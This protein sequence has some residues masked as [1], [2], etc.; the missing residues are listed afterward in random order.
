VSIGLKGGGR[1]KSVISALVFFFVIKAGHA[2]EIKK[3]FEIRKPR[4][5][6]SETIVTLNYSVHCS[7]SNEDEVRGFIHY[8]GRKI[9]V[10][11]FKYNTRTEVDLGTSPKTAET[12]TLEL[13]PTGS[14]QVRHVEAKVGY[15]ST[16]VTGNETED[17]LFAKLALKYSPFVNL[18]ENQYESVPNDTPLL[19]TY[20]V[21]HDS[22][23]GLTSI[24]YTVYFSDE[25]TQ[26]DTFQTNAQMARFGRAADI[27]WAYEVVLNQ[28]LRP[29]A[30]AYQGALHRTQNFHGSYLPGAFFKK[31]HP[32]LLNYN[33]SDNNVFTDQSNSWLDRVFHPQ[34]NQGRVGHHLVPR[35]KM[36]TAAPREDVMFAHPWMFRVTETE[37]KR[38][39]KAGPPVQENLF[40]RFEGELNQGSFIGEVNSAE[41]E[42]FESGG[43]QCYAMGCDVNGLG[44]LHRYSAIP[45]GNGHLND[46][47]SGKFHGQFKLRGTRY[48]GVN[49]KKLKF[50]RMHASS[51]TFRVEEISDK[52]RCTYLKE[53]TVC[54][55]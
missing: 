14:C 16:Q 45:L 31:T 54:R 18:R 46:L 15:E 32:V 29:V 41:G 39:N 38:Q 40:V 4:P 52:F 36:D 10:D 20:S 21:S 11:L 1:V 5:E 34:Q 17:R 22:S 24:L 55:F 13:E 44:P 2:A 49:L 47:S 33:V 37:I 42:I 6:E 48:F 51:S 3:S 30:K 50:Y 9:I 35:I 8:Q 28:K 23:H 27:E 53:Q 7:S 25:D 43:S 12:A 19:M 26:S